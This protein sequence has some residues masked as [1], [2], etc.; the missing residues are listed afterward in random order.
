M[1]EGGN[2]SPAVSSSSRSS[3]SDRSHPIYKELSKMNREVNRL[4]NEEIKLKLRKENL[5]DL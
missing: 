4:T 3:T 5:S 2:G 1:A